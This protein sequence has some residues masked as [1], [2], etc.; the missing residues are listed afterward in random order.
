MAGGLFRRTLAQCWE[1]ADGLPP[2]VSAALAATA[3]HRLSDLS[4]VLAVPEFQVPLPGGGRPSQND[5]FVLARSRAGPVSIMVEGKVDE[6]FGPTL[7]QWRSDASRRKADRL[8]FLLETLGPP[9]PPDDGIRYQLLHR[10]A[11]AVIE[12]QR[13][14]AAAAVLLIHSFSARSAG[15]PDYQAF[16]RLYGIDA[17][18]GTAQH[19][20]GNTPIPLFAAWVLGDPR[21]LRS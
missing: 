10:A 16:L 11:S 21:F 13:Y 5:I 17:T 15:W 2:E 7:G 18:A 14:R 6:T 9:A 1:A 8:A 3:D 12:G 4:P 20:P 19:L